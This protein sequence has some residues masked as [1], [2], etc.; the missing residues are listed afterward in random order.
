MN[1]QS[2]KDIKA[3]GKCV[4]VRVDFNVP[5]DEQQQITDDTRIRAALPTLRYLLG[6]G[7]KLILIS[8]LGR[9]KGQVN[10][11]Y[12]LAPVAARLGELLGQEIPLAQDCIGPEVMEQVKALKEGQVLL[13]ENVR[14]H[15]E[16]E[17]NNPEFA[18]QLASLAEIYVNDAF[19]TAHRAHASTEGVTHYI[20]AVAGLLLEKEIE[21]MGKALE[22]PA[23]PFVAIIGGAKVSDKI[24]VIENLLSKVNVLIIGGGMANTFLKAQGYSIGKSLVE[25]DKLTLASEL[26]A[27]AKTLGVEIALPQ[28]V[29]VAKE[30][31][32][33]AEYRTVPVNQIR[34]D[35][36]ALDIGPKSAEVFEN[37][38]AG[39]QT[40]VWNGPMGVF[41][42]ENFAKGTEKVA[43][44]VAACSGTTIVGGG[45]SV[46]AVEKMGVAEQL[47]HISTGGG[48]SLE[49]LEGKVLPGVAAL[50]ERSSDS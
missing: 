7:A 29:I 49:F 47:T 1:K 9:P 48:A 2:V 6:E 33:E 46:A 38:L 4:L 27:K 24:G 20:P 35:E 31:K 45:D 14:F 26:L 22:N 50:N 17:K 32:A 28:D 3:Q 40:V 34:E 16:E 8:H 37:H 23:R 42:M 11:K 15:A 44:A 36:M 41:E 19:G 30:F 5:M 10:S 43:Q 21:V 25:E 18:K 12:S 13:L 39:A